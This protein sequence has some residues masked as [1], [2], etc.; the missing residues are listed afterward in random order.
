M[1]EELKHPEIA[2]VRWHMAEI[3]RETNDEQII[4]HLNEA[5][6]ALTDLEHNIE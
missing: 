2:I 3:R 4:K 1:G 6:S 5:R